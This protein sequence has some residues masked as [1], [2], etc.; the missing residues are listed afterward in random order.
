MCRVLTQVY[1]CGHTKPVCISSCYRAFR[2]S[3]PPPP[4]PPRLHAPP[5][6]GSYTL[7]TPNTQ[8]SRSR[9]TSSTSHRSPSP[10]PTWLLELPMYNPRRAYCRPLQYQHLPK[11]QFP[12]MECYIKPE[13]AAYQRRWIQQYVNTHPGSTA[14][15]TE[16]LEG[17]SGLGSGAMRAGV[18]NVMQEMD[19]MR[20]RRS[21][22][23]GS[24][25]S[26]ARA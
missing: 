12:C 23:A 13:W 11:S 10:T 24:S 1:A 15:S 2:P 25:E 8:G 3:S 17:L 9:R 6:P 16:R 18:I 14:E 5:F 21:S 22:G 26:D 4:P 20:T 7:H 19:R